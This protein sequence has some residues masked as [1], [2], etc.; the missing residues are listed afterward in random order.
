MIKPR[1]IFVLLMV[2]FLL[3]ALSSQAAEPVTQKPATK[4]W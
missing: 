1:E 4:S 3:A 2:V